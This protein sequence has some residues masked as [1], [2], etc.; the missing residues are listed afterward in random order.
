MIGTE[1]FELVRFLTDRDD[2]KHLRAILPESC[3]IIGPNDM[4]MSALMAGVGT[5]GS[6]QPQPCTLFSM[7]EGHSNPD[8]WRTT[9]SILDTLTERHAEEEKRGSPFRTALLWHGVE[10]K[11]CRILTDLFM[12]EPVANF[13]V[14]PQ[15]HLLLGLVSQLMG[16]FQDIDA[17][18]YADFLIVVNAVSNQRYGT[19]DFNGNTSRRLLLPASCA[20]MR[21]MI[22]HGLHTARRA[23]E[24]A[25]SAYTSLLLHQLC[26]VMESLSAV[27]NAVMGG[28]LNPEYKDVIQRYFFSFDHF[29]VT[30]NKRKPVAAKRATNRYTM[31]Q[32]CLR[33]EVPRRISSTKR[34]LLAD[35]EQ[36]A[37][38]VHSLEAAQ[39]ADFKIP[40]L[41]QRRTRSSGRGQTLSRPAQSA[42]SRL[43]DRLPGVSNPSDGTR[44]G[45]SSRKRTRAED[46]VKRNSTPVRKKPKQTVYPSQSNLNAVRVKRC[47]QMVAWNVSCVPR[48]QLGVQDR[49]MELAK[50]RCNCEK[51]VKFIFHDHSRGGDDKRVC[52]C[53][54]YN[55]GPRAPAL[56]SNC[57]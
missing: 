47:Q 12:D 30:Y 11:P 36:G 4:K 46:T 49:I 22:P 18:L 56:V 10:T 39:A 50:W 2:Y 37:E 48:S 35:S 54:P 3:E 14:P 7:Y 44:S 38:A 41:A 17:A 53:A 33:V 28:V 34:S 42:E 52:G 40:I 13:L 32:E 27:V 26:D 51:P 1:N 43:A 20:K 19:T 21:N 9:R 5:S 24:P 6:R 45:Q 57:Q 29:V 31:K 8:S 55:P 25:S 23:L 15:L 16:Y